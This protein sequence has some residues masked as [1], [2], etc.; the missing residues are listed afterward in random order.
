M[1]Q[2]G[3]ELV[4][5]LIERYNRKNVFAADIKAKNS[6]LMNDNEN[7]NYLDCTDINSLN[8][9]VTKNKIDTIYHLVAI[10]SAAAEKKPQAAWHVNMSSLLNVLEVAREHK[11]SIFIPSSIAVF[12]HNSPVMHTPQDTIQRPSTIYGITKA[13]GEMLCDYYFRK[14]N[15]D[16][17]GVRYPG[18]ISYKT[19]PGGGTTD[20]AVDIFYMA[21]REKKYECYLRES[22][23][24]DF[25]YMPDAVKAA[26]NLMEADPA[27]LKHRN[28][29]N[30]TSMS[31]T[32]KL[33][34]GEIK[35]IIPEFEISYKVDPERQSIADT[36]PKS[37]NDYSARKDWNWKPDYDLKSMTADMIENLTRKLLIERQ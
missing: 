17:R 32:P 12:G 3:T 20:Y 35:K 9:F 37:I 26:I 22:T 34:A 24:L 27:K 2:I 13:A 5:V 18:I 7:Y 36:W 25:M 23:Y 10:L 16:T 1:G 31:I 15:V 6:G 21:V 28:A 4:S 19:L 33:I 30:V 29:Y 11:C 14:Y 8:D